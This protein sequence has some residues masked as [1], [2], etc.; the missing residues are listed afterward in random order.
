MRYKMF[1]IKFD[2][3]K[4]KSIISPEDMLPKTVENIPFDTGDHG[5]AGAAL[6]TKTIKSENNEAKIPVATT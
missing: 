5:V 6:E 4:E 3:K 2:P 1:K